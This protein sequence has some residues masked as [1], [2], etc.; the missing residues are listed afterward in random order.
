MRVDTR[1]VVGVLSTTIAR[2]DVETETV[3]FAA[4]EGA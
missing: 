1:E 4:E 2:A 3:V